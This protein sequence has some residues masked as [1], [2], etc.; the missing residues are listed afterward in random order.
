MKKIARLPADDDNS[1]RRH[2]RVVRWIDVHPDYR[3]RK[4]PFLEPTG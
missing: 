4:E 3:T 1:D 2:R